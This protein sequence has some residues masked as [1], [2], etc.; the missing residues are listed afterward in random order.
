VRTLWPRTCPKDVVNN[1]IMASH[2]SYYPF[3][4]FHFPNL[5]FFLSRLHGRDPDWPSNIF[6]GGGVIARISRM[7]RGKLC[8]R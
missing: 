8:L 5:F 7:G 6:F 2:G 4:F 3:Q 1:V